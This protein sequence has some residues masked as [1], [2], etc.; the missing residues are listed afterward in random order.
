MSMH[1]ALSIIIPHYNHP[2][3]LP[4]LLRSIQEQQFSDLEVIVVD[5]CSER[6]CEHV[7]ADFAARGLPVRLLKSSG[8]VF[9]KNARILGIRDARADIIAFADC[10]DEF[11]NPPSL[12]KH[13]AE[14]RLARADVLHFQA[15][16]IDGNGNFLSDVGPEAPFAEH[17]EDGEILARFVACGR[18]N[19]VWGKLYA[20]NLCLRVADAAWDIPVRRYAEDQ[21]LTTLLLFHARRYVGSEVVGYRH[22]YRDKR[23][24]ESAERAVYQYVMLTRVAPYL[25][26][27]GCPER[28]LRDFSRLLRQ[29]LCLNAGRFCQAAC[30]DGNFLSD[31]LTDG[32]L[33]LAD[34]RTW[35]K[36]LA[37]GN[38]MNAAKLVRMTRTALGVDDRAGA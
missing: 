8:R 28:V 33:E 34:E 16:T 23:D 11:C 25:A 26:E 21:C 32:M 19:P 20:R 18:G 38:G 15:V 27:N 14:F 3:E 29:K 1:P 37:L 24:V 17:L 36:I 30:G 6:T 4:G 35:L 12:G 13:V 7:A 22:L 31:A 9:T 2:D 10:D 5:D